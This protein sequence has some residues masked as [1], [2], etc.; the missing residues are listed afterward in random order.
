M[1]ISNLSNGEQE[2]LISMRVSAQGF[3]SDSSH[4]SQVANYLATFASSKQKDPTDFTKILGKVLNQLLDSIFY[5]HDP[6]GDVTVSISNLGQLTGIKLE[7]PVN[8]ENKAI[9][10][11]LRQALKKSDPQTLYDQART[12]PEG[13][14]S[15][16]VGSILEVAA[17]HQAQ[18]EATNI[19]GRNAVQLFLKI[20][21]EAELHSLQA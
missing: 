14:S 13:V 3:A 6:G 8:Y 15:K 7:F 11:K 12:Q 2:F 9:Y 5:N 21:L 16:V 18:L 10:S 19:L 1:N 4:S 20:N 17:R